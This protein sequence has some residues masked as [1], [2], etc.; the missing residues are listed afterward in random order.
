MNKSYDYIFSNA[1]KIVVIAIISYVI[2]KQLFFFAFV[3]I[4]YW[5]PR[6]IVNTAMLILALFITRNKKLTSRQMSWMAPVSFSLLEITGAVLIGGDQMLYVALV[7]CALLSLL[8]VD[9]LGL[10]ITALVNCTGA[11][12]CLFLFDFTMLGE[13][14]PFESDLYHYLGMAALNG[15]IFSMGKYIIRTIVKSRKAEEAAQKAASRVETIIGKLPGMVYQHLYDFPECTI[16]YV[17]DGSRE[18]IGYTPEELIGGPNKFMAMVHPD[19]LEGMGNKYSKAI[20]AG[21]TYEQAYRIIMLDG[22]IK[23]IMDRCTAFEKN[24]DGTPY[25]VE[26]YM[27]DITEQKKLEAAELTTLMLDTSP[28]CIQL[29]D[30]DINTIDCNEAAVKLYGF[31]DKQEYVERFIKDCSPE[32][33]PDG[34]LSSEKAVML[35]NKAF[36]EGRRVF[37]WMHKMPDGTP[38]PA[39]ITLVRVRYKDDYLVVGYTR[40]LREVVRLEA[41]AEKAYY[42]ALTGIYNRRFFDE[43]LNRLLK[44]LSRSGGVLSLLMI[45]IDFFKKYNDTYGHSEGDK[46]LKTIAE[47]LSKSIPRIDDFVV[48]YGGEEFA[49]VLPNTNEFGARLIAEK[50]LQNIR[51]R[52]IPHEK[53]SIAKFV[54]ISIGAITGKAEHTQNAGDY[55]KRA[56][57]MLYKA[58]QSGR[59]KYIFGEL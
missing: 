1:K 56:D 38:M 46:C 45:D 35:V 15:I 51:Y 3:D 16:T 52:N 30:R 25:S 22:S 19:D 54:T 12:L 59:N 13:I 57:D 34:Q 32:Y 31:K 42:D 48:R 7:G 2:I 14:Y 37:D 6:G 53:S 23:W 20:E 36:E 55:I 43:N 5:L 27:F 49:V 8:F 10:A 9:T 26:G 4:D 50:L 41:E 29:W 40:D 33:Q 18:F 21:L 11:A 44:T 28:L 47:T 39:E 17:S 58:K 24:P